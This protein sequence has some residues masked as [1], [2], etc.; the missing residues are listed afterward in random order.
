MAGANGRHSSDLQQ[1]ETVGASRLFNGLIPARVNLHRI[2]LKDGNWR[3]AGLSSATSTRS[4]NN[5][6][7]SDALRF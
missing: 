5:S 3:R 6:D 4:S 7:M 1:R 2:G